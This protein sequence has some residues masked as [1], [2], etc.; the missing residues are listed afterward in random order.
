MTT[1]DETTR[2]ALTAFPSKSRFR[3]VG[4]SIAPDGRIVVESLRLLR[5]NVFLTMI[6]LVHAETN[7]LL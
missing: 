2:F 5:F 6:K 7:K 1:A 4:S 3:K